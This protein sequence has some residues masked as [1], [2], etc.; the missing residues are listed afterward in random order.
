MTLKELKEF[1]VEVMM[2]KAKAGKLGL[3][4]TMHSIESATQTVG[5]EIAELIDEGKV[6]VKSNNS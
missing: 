1:A 4:K 2:L 6:D 3:W 5:W